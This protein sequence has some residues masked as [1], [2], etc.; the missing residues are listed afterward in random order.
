M[1]G[2]RHQQHAS[3]AR[4]TSKQSCLRATKTTSHL[5]LVLE[6]LHAALQ[7]LVVDVRGRP[8]HERRVRATAAKPQRETTQANQRNCANVWF[9]RRGKSSETAL[10]KR[11]REQIGVALRPDRRERA[12]RPDR[13]K[14][15]VPHPVMMRTSTPRRAACRMARRIEAGGIRKGFVISTLRALRPTAQRPRS[16][17][18]RRGIS[19]HQGGSPS[20][21]GSP[22]RARQGF[23]QAATQQESAANTQRTSGDERALDVQL[24]RDHI[25]R[26]HLNENALRGLLRLPRC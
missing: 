10:R 3:A 22:R 24:V 26:Q 23:P 12:R 4:R 13:A 11:R 5:A 19:M 2:P 1:P 7:E 8:A 15:G 16:D 25:R 14:Q 6:N 21:R 9:E 20:A 17:T 18:K